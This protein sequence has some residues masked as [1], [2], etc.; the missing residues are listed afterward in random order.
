MVGEKRVGLKAEYSGFLHWIPYR[1]IKKQPVIFTPLKKSEFSYR[2]D[3]QAK[4]NSCFRAT[5]SPQ[6]NGFVAIP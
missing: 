3:S 4:M 1:L 5:T 2:V 6:P